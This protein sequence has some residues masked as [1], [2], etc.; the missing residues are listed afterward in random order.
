MPFDGTVDIP[1]VGKV[2]KLY[3]WVAIGGVGL[4]VGWRYYQ[5]AKAPAATDVP[6]TGDVGAPVD[7]SG[8]IGA[9]ASGNV[10]YAGTTTQ[11]DAS[12][13]A[14]NEQ[15]TARAVEL[16]SA[17]GIDPAKVY[18]ALGDFLARRPLDNQEQQI[19]SS[20][21]AAA[22]QPPV[23]GPYSIIPQVGPVSLTAPTGLKVVST[24]TTTATVTFNAVP[25]AAFYYLYRDGIKDNISGSRDTKITASGLTRGTQYKLSVAAAA[26]TGKL[27]PR[28][29]TVTATTKK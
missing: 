24:T 1:K 29:G 9:P 11:S 28:S 20:A 7:A 8:V 23:G 25:G 4:F 14:T 13:I 12:T 27:G 26:T 19:V 18:Q 17:A 21:I 3:L 2:K 5:A 15:W 22:G 16:L 10:Q 6:A